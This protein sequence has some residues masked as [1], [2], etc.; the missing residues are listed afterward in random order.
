[1][2]TKFI[3]LIVTF[4]FAS[5]AATQAQT[6]LTAWTFDNLPIGI[7]GSP[8][9]STGLG[10]VNA[11]GMNNG[12]NNTNSA[13]NPDIQALAGSSSGG[14]NC[15]RIRGFNAS[16]LNRGNGWSTNAAVG[17]QGAQFS[18]STY[19]YYEIKVSFDVYATAD[20]EANL[21]VQY[22]TDGKT[23]FNANVGS[24]ASGLIATNT[25]SSN[26]VSGTY[27]RLASGWNDQVTVDLSGLSGVDNTASFAL[28]IVNASTATDCVDTTGAVYNN[29]S[30]SWSLDN[31]VIQGTSIDTI[32][33]W[34]FDLIGVTLP[35]YNTPAPTVGSGTAQSLGMINNYTFS[36]SPSDIGSSNWCDVLAQG[37]ASTGP[38]SLC[39]RVRGGQ[40]GA[41]APN[42]GWNSAA[43]LFT[44]GA[45]YDVST[46]GYTNI[47]CYFDIYFTTQAPDKFCVFYTTDGWA[48][49]NLANSLFYGAAP[50]YIH[51]NAS[52]PNLVNGNYFYENFGQ[53]WYN[54]V[55][56]D[57]SGDPATANNPKF[58]FRVVN[59]GTGPQ[60][61][62]FLGQAYN[63]L[64]GNWRFD[65]VTVG[66][67]SGTPAPTVVFDPN[68]T[69]DHPFTNTYTDEPAWRTNI[70]AIYVN[71]LI[72]TN[73]AYTTTNAGE[74]IF[75]PAK[76][77]L[78]ESSG[79]LNISIISSGFGTARVGQPLAA[80]AATKLAVTNAVAG[81]SASGGTLTANPVFLVSDQYG[82]GTTNPC[83][84]VTIT[85]SVGGAGAWT[86][87]G[88]AQQSSSNGVIAF[89]NLAATL[90]GSSPITNAYITY[91]VA[92]YGATFNTNSSIFKIGAPPVPFT[93]GNLAVFQVD[94]ADDNSTFSIIEV[95]PSVARQAAAVNIVPISATGTNAL[96]ESSAGATGRLALSD[97]GTLLCFSAFADG[98]AATPDE[99]FILN[100]APA[101]MNYSN[102][103]IM[104]SYTSISLGGSE[105][106][107]ACVLGD[108]A[109]WI[110][111][112][113]GGLYE[114]QFAGGNLLQPNL[115]NFNN[116]VVRTFGGT[117]YVETQKAV[118]GES[119]PEIYALG[120]DPST[121]LYDVT[122][123]DNLGT[124]QYAQDFY[125]ISTNSGASY[126]VL[127]VS[128]EVSATLGV[129][130]KFSL[131]GGN[132][133]ANGSYTNSTGVDGLFA[134]TNGDGGVS[135]F[136]TT[137]GGG[138]P[139]NSIVRVTDATGWNQ[140]ISIV[141][142]NLLYTAAGSATLKGL[143]FV[144]QRTTNGVQL[145]PPPILIAQNGASVTNTFTIANTPADPA[146]HGAI[147]GITV[148]GS[149]LPPAAYN[150]AASNEIVFN[151]AQ[152]V[153]LQE[154]GA[155]TIA[156]IAAGY[157]AATVIQTLAEITPSIVDSVSL[158][159]RDLSFTLTSTPSLTLT[160]LSTTNVALPLSQW[161]TVGNATE[162]PAGH[163]Q[164]TDPSPAT[165]AALFYTV[166]Q[167]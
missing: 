132:W 143:T 95:S 24:A 87:G 42:S 6:T 127:Y 118:F 16:G 141:S 78:L 131:V 150:I 29:T 114:G 60:C 79:L 25:T 146:W 38:N 154:P 162:G 88:A 53:G 75:N 104:G 156:V 65:N 61:Q 13:S 101:A 115:N 48:T 36:D 34:D 27:I 21:Q 41:G 145:M 166:I 124:D 47:I 108:D 111:V 28:R 144:P 72:L 120:F 90:L 45:E 56:V 7:N 50:A 81:P 121:G 140:N 40:T 9:P 22:S 33:D 161:R 66:G 4:F 98:S 84:N 112:D 159:G 10:A 62:N 94:T 126:D 100:R 152:S 83:T 8:Q 46:A 113:K 86:L 122:F 106:R 89:T 105:A 125:L 165:N 77:P 155:K 158:N 52:D 67:T 147:T 136:Y 76:S 116:V 103:L 23:W 26:T 59:A 49:T 128:D 12:Y 51:T 139:T 160:V 20:A 68:A 19:G 130:N 123:P 142:S 137:G 153:L 97:D 30:G 3:A 1:M 43:P 64:S 57:L 102:Q 80:G 164:F 119:I 11:L 93:P 85:A 71:G 70:A 14:P 55:V 17:T 54:N 129:I 15:W 74:I 32:A 82:N 18:G 39:W 31:V 92:G 63:N 91:S 138:T 5:V 151:T 58:G 149:P 133:I 110:A 2:R 109:T 73:A 167:P 157:S 99:T 69:V 117:P 163:Y 35:P 107:A 44:Q 134:T 96:R 135:L 148:N 37:G